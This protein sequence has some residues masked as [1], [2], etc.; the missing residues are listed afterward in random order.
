MSP[1]AV[2]RR[3]LPFRSARSLRLALGATL[4]LSSAAPAQQLVADIAAGPGA[5]GS[6]E[7]LTASGGIVFFTAD[8]GVHGREVWWTNGT[9]AAMAVDLWPGSTS[10]GAAGLRPFL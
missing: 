5:H 2:R 8:D 4:V 3:P 6:P 10:S 7:N 1:L 9:T